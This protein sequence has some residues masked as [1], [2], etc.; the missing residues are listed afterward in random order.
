MF[1]AQNWVLIKYKEHVN[2]ITGPE[3]LKN[4]ISGKI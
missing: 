4:I 2:L 1:L 3:E